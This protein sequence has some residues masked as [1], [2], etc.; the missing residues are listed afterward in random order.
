MMKIIA[1]F[2][3]L[4]SALS[5]VSCANTA[6]I[7]TL[8]E[9]VTQHLT[10]DEIEQSLRRVE[11]SRLIEAW[12]EPDRR[13]AH[14]NEDVWVLDD[15]KVLIISYNLGGRVDDAEIED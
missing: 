2:L 12:G 6:E 15:G 4:A 10:D 5:V 14:E 1:L 13:I 11:R 7:I 3:I 8:E 9:I